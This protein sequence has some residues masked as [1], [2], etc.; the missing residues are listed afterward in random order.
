MS[1]IFSQKQ[2]NFLKEPLH[3]INAL[4]GVTAS[5]KSFISNLKWYYEICSNSQKK[6]YLQ[7]GNTSETLYD[8]ITSKLLEID[9]GI[10]WL[11]YK[12]IEGRRRIIVRKTGT[13]VACIGAD[14][15]NAYMRIRGKNLAGW[16]A[17]EVT[18]QPKSFIQQALACCRDI[19]ND[20]LVITPAL[21]TMNPDTPKHFLK[22]EYLNNTEIDIK[23]WIFEFRDNPLMTDE[24]INKLK[25]KFTGI[26]YQRMIMG[27]WTIAQG[28][29]YDNFSPAFHTQYTLSNYPK[30][31]IVRYK[32]GIDWGY[33]HPMVIGLFGIDNDGVYYLIDSLYLR[34][35]LINESLKE[36]IKER[37]WYDYK[38]EEAYGDPSRPDYI[39]QFQDITGIET[40]PANNEVIEGIQEVQKKLVVG[41]NNKAQLYILDHNKEVIEEFQTYHWKE[42]KEG[43]TKDEVVK[44]SDD[45]VDMCRYL[46][47]SDRNNIDLNNL[48]L[49]ETK[50]IGVSK[51]W[52]GL[53]EV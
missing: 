4:V 42:T 7:S 48:P 19:K 8:N 43:V 30:E 29:V 34:K 38:I 45:G 17:D 32:V 2:I 12:S 50:S 47:Y 40:L 10:N 5:S 31:T 28:V 3:E 6:L 13:E 33:E 35:Q 23:Q 26:F 52:V 11:E 37:G 24:I 25:Q 39:D 41:D 21:W 15:D 53:K 51:R 18:K 9:K 16:Y 44:E 1:I 22:R 14:D 36:K 46:I 27:L 20:K 49:I